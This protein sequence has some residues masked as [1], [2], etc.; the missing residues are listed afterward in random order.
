[1]LPAM[2]NDIA[3]TH[4]RWRLGRLR[5]LA[6]GAVLLAIVGCDQDKLTGNTIDPSELPVEEQE[7]TPPASSP[8]VT[9]TA[10]I[11][12][13]AG[14]IARC[15][16]R[17][18][19]A[20]ADLLDEIGGTVFTLGDN[21]R[22]SGTSAD[23]KDCYGP[24]WG[25]HKTRTRP[26]AGD[27]DYKT[28]GAS[29]YFGYFGSAAGDP[30][31]GYYSY[32]L[33]AWHVVVLNSNTSMS[34]GSAQERWLKADLAA[35]DNQCT[36]AYWHHPRFS[37]YSTSVRSSTKP[38]WD[39]LYA[40]GADLVINGHY[41]LYERFAPQ[42]PD[43]SADPEN[44]IRQIT[45]GT[46]G[47]GVED[48][49]RVRPNSEV[50]RSGAYG[51]LKLSLGSGDYAWKFVP[52]AGQTFT[53]GGSG[54]CHRRTREAG[55]EVSPETA[56]LAP[57]QVKQFTATEV[58]SDGTTT[59]ASATWK[60]TGGT[61]DSDGTYK[62]GTKTGTFHVIASATTG[63]GTRVDTAEVVVTDDAPEI[64][65]IVVTPSSVSL[66]AGE[67]ERFSAKAKMS[68]GTTTSVSASWT[69]TG[70]T[71]DTAGLYKAGK[72][73]G[74]YRVIARQLNGTLADTAT[75]AISTETT[76]PSDGGGTATGD[77]YV[78]TNGSDANPG[79]AAA[80]F[81]TLQKAAN[82]V[83]PGD[84]VIVRD[85]VYTGGSSG[86]DLVSLSRS[87]SSSAWIVFRAE[88]KWGAVLDGRNNYNQ[89]GIDFGSVSYV[90]IEGFEIR[91]FQGYGFVLYG[92]GH[93]LA[94]VG[95]HV[96]TI[97]R[98]C[99][100]TNNGRT[101]VSIGEGTSRVLFEGNVWHDIGRFADGE[102][103]CNTGNTYYM[104]HDHG[105]YVAE[106][107]EITIR[108]NVFY[109]FKRGWAIQRYATSGYRVAG[110]KILNNTFVGA[111]P[112]REGHI[113]LATATSGLQ[114]ENNIFYNP[115]GG[116]VLVD[117]GSL[118]GTVRANVTYGGS[119]TVGGTGGLTVSGNWNNTDPRFISS[120]N[121]R[122]QSGSPAVDVGLRLSEVARD[123]D[124]VARPQGGGHD[125]GAYERQ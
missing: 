121:F 78:A 57:S 36:L 1:M 5:Q 26:A 34:A 80:P 81:R 83:G 17:K 87:G 71:V 99:T 52:I 101:G 74:T 88:R 93:D 22:A 46:G 105:I 73:S 19:E 72:T 9:G 32:N 48:F 21:I 92:G 15:D 76:P 75:V 64:T 47:H 44:G 114:I 14:Q 94:V 16:D 65:G 11:L 110:L 97:G 120:S 70:G 62:S 6:V 108:N 111:N 122:L 86:G 33:G 28:S 27:L 91:G 41:R 60:A 43:G 61:I 82:V 85:G 54:I 2:G 4:H 119:A 107:D 63:S 39:A 50:R 38:L 84:T 66:A 96:H 37:S 31:K 112:Y 23:Y 104:N 124:G 35:N 103:G 109:N 40:A 24:T 55:L 42:A 45:V 58:R 118:S 59:P 90:R 10:Q 13:G 30:S 125:V 68:D 117:D 69:A 98:Y 89:T 106:G 56:T 8:A 113:I 53:D 51:V 29:G 25:R 115:Q 79:T 18:D 67:T 77:Y 123:A 100:D 20:T 49:D 116:G 3:I 7:I 95:N 102:S 12:V